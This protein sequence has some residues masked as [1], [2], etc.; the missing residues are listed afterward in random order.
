LSAP[1]TPGV[2][3]A[4]TLAIGCSA[5]AAPLPATALPAPGEP[6]AADDARCIAEVPYEPGDLPTVPGHRSAKAGPRGEP[7]SVPSSTGADVAPRAPTTG[8]VVEGEKLGHDPAVAVGDRFMMVYTAHRY[9]LYDKATGQLLA[10]EEDDE[11][12]VV[13]D[14]STLFSPL[15]A[16]RDKR[17]VP[18]Q[19]SVNKRLR[20]AAGDPLLCDPEDPLGKGSPAC[21]R[22]FYDSRVL[23]DPDH[24]R[25]WIESAARNHL[26]F[27]TRSPTEPCT[28]PKWSPSQPRRFIAVAVSRTED[29]RKGW[30]RYVLVDEYADWPKMA[31]HE[32]Y[33]VLGHRGSPN[34]Y[35]FDAD[36]LAA[37][38]PD[39]GP[40]RL[41]KLDAGSFSGARPGGAGP[42]SSARF[43]DPVT[44]HGP[45][46]GVTFL[47]GTDESDRVTVF[48][49]MSPDPSR[50][51]PPVLVA[52]PRVS[53]GTKVSNFENN[54]VYR[55]GK[56]YLTWDECT[57]GHDG[58]T[59]GH[60]DCGPRRIRVL[61]LPASRVAGKAALVASIDPAQGYLNTT[62]GGREP[63]DAPGD[64]AD[65]VKPVL[66]VT[67]AGDVVLGYARRGFRTRAPMPFELRYSILYHGE[68]APRPA[69][70]VRRGTWAEA[71]DIDDN[72]KAGIDLAGA[73]TDPD[74]QRVWI[75]HA[76]ADGPMKWFRQVT[77]SVK[78]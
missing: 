18:N 78:P 58:G 7:P 33:L 77:V 72:S 54:A 62:F 3:L 56:I 63:D 15:W 43:I 39:R 70:L 75:S 64:V 52:A 31:I 28:D 42:V 11:V 24:K 40:V 27:C 6:G 65:Y 51:A 53:I 50:A 35:V 74:D 47:V 76:V 41:A 32:R 67:A 26:W 73:Q 34:V 4:A 71:P 5:G 20:F 23:W 37:G 60:E 48:G 10:P 38:N 66:D 8:L 57:P 29:P 49:L 46:G 61:R 36:K 2:A 55:D 16:P 25:F 22:E 17:G 59:P 19:A 44:H 13:G 21:V 12:A 45:T 14:F 69:A 9:Q 30:H 68:A 1:L